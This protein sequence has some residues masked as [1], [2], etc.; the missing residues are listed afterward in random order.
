MTPDGLMTHLS[1]RSRVYALEW[2]WKD[3]HS[4][5]HSCPAMHTPKTKSKTLNSPNTTPLFSCPLP[6]QCAAGRRPGSL[7]DAPRGCSTSEAFTPRTVLTENI[8][9]CVQQIIE[10]H[11]AIMHFLTTSTITLSCLDS[12]APQANS[13]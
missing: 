13:W 6:V 9:R 8:C 5:I 4:H 3:I 2:H 1:P 7:A 12:A 10:H 11:P